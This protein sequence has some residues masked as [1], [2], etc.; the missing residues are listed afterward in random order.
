MPPYPPAEIRVLAV[1]DDPGLLDIIRIFLESTGN[2]VVSRDMCA[3]DALYTLETEYFDVCIS[4][5]DMPGMNGVQFIRKI[6][7]DGYDLPCILM[8]GN[9]RKEVHDAALGAGA[10]CVIQKGGK[11]P[12][13]FSELAEAVKEAAERGPTSG[14]PGVRTSDGG[15]DVRLTVKGG[16]DVS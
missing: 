8:T 15:R 11:G 10:W 4:D 6:R 2:I 9:R 12:A 3:R 14:Y 7:E 16:A 13:F 5:F 1:D